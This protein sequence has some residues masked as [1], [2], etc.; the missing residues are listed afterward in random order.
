MVNPDIFQTGDSDPYCDTPTL[1]K[2][3]CNNIHENSAQL[4]LVFGLVEFEFIFFFGGGRGNPQFFLHTWRCTLP[5]S[6]LK[7]PLG[8]GWWVGGWWLESEYSDRLWLSFS[9]AF[10]K[11][12]N[13]SRVFLNKWCGFS[14]KWCVS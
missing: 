13:K 1:A 4:E 12:N 11:P 5:G 3:C 10:A 14:F 9:L 7:V 6:A 8:G 2:I